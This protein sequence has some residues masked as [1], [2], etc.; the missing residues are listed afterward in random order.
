MIDAGDDE[1]DA[2]ADHL[3]QYCKLDTFAMVEIYRLL[4]GLECTI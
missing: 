2:I 4:N 3:L 1:A